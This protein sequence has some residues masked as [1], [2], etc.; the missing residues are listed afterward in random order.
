MPNWFK[1]LLALGA[2]CVAIAFYLVVKEGGARDV[3]NKQIS[4]MTHDRLKSAY[5]DYTT[6]GFRTSTSFEAFEEFVH[7]L[8]V[9]NKNAS[10]TIEKEVGDEKA[11]TLEVLLKSTEGETATAEFVLEKEEG[12]WKVV[13]ITLQPG[14]VTLRNDNAPEYIHPVQTQ[15]EEL[16]KGNYTEA[17]DGL[18]SKDFQKA[19]PSS[20]YKTFVDTYPI[21]RSFTSLSL[22]EHQVEGN[23]AQ[24][25]VVLEDDN[26]KVPVEYLLIKEDGKWKIRGMKLVISDQYLDASSLDAALLKPIKEQMAALSEN[27]IEAAYQKNVSDEF[28]KA[29]TLE[30]FKSFVKNHPILTR[31]T[32]LNITKGVSKDNLA[33]LLVTVSNDEE[34]A[35]LEY[36]L[37]K[38]GADWD[39]LA[40]QF[41]ESENDSKTK[42][43]SSASSFDVPQFDAQPLQKTIEG[44]LNLVKKKEFEEAYQTYASA[45]F[46]ESTTLEQFKTFLKDQPGFSG[47][48]SFN[49]DRLSFNGNIGTYNG[50]VTDGK[51]RQYPVEF[52]LLKENGVWKILHIEVLPAGKKSTPTLEPGE[53]EARLNLPQEFPHA[54]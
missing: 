39:I 21:L 40:V 47:N 27:N 29:T 38:N 4:A 17:Y 41:F 3:V 8:P 45:E 33:K 35:I 42:P 9:L 14:M 1:I 24:A 7:K 32:T 44:M 25:I 51:G 6:Q 15:L 52:D 13:T 48:S 18:V 11:A 16:R 49:F 36:T 26:E 19:T 12:Q 28:H 23:E 34:S 31:Y 30:E 50:T 2:L 54:A 43:T 22:G 20:Q 46:K 53:R 37:I 10:Y 5:N